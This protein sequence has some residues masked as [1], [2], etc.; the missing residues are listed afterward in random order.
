MTSVRPEPTAG[1]PPGSAERLNADGFTFIRYRLDTTVSTMDVANGL[2][3]SGPV[4]WVVVTADEQTGGRGTR[5]RSWSSCKGKGLWVSVILPPPEQAVDLSGFTVSAAEALARSLG[6]IAGC[7][8]KI[9]HPNDLIANGRKIAGLL[10]ETAITG[11]KVRPVILGFGVNFLQTREDFD[12]DGLPDATSLLIETGTAPDRETVLAAFLGH[13]KRVYDSTV[14][15]VRKAVRA[16]CRD[17]RGG[18]R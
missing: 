12:R 16:T 18:V 11:D 13:L 3:R 10:A 5:G 6:E 7:N 1:I 4:S 2:V 17:E 8:C 9:K 15:G 14:P